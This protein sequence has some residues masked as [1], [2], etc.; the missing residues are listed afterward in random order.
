MPF[1]CGVLATYLPDLSL[2]EGV[3]FVDLDQNVVKFHSSNPVPKFSRISNNRNINKLVSNPKKQLNGNIRI[4][5][6]EVRSA[7]IS[8]FAKFLRNYKICMNPSTG[9]SK[10]KF[11]K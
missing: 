11:N 7:F 8:F 10:D 4:D 2:L 3:V 5:D 1:I 6:N 9:P